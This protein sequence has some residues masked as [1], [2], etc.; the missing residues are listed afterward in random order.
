MENKDIIYGFYLV[1]FLDLL[2][3][4]EKIKALHGKLGTGQ[5][6]SEKKEFIKILRDS[7]GTVMRFRNGLAQF[8]ETYL[9]DEIS[10]GFPQEHLEKYNKLRK[11]TEIKIRSFSDS[12]V[13]W[14]PVQMKDEFEFAHVLNSIHGVLNAIAS[15]MLTNFSQGFLFRGGLDLEGGLE[16][17]EDEIYGPGLLEAYYLESKLAKYPRVL[18]GKG[19]M[20]FLEHVL[21]VKFTDDNL[22]RYCNEMIKLCRSLIVNDQDGLPMIHF[23]GPSMLN[24][25]ENPKERKNFYE[26]TLVPLGTFIQ[27]NEIIFKMDNSLGPRYKNFLNYY[28]KYVDAW[29]GA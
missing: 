4:R 29:K 25:F 26:E 9:D 16:I 6:N 10:D 2:G 17:D 1:V 8:F 20:D 22:R 14:I 13:I 27:E 21:S 19:L 28:N 24:L 5:I 15:M 12:T 23:L 3:Q 18:I 11:R 7:A